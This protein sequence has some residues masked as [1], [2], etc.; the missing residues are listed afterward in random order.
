MPR[1]D[2]PQKNDQ[3]SSNAT[4]T[5]DEG[6]ENVGKIRPPRAMSS[7]H[8]PSS[9]GTM[10]WSETQRII[11][12]DDGRPTWCSFA[13]RRGRWGGAPSGRGCRVEAPSWPRMS[14]NIKNEETSSPESGRKRWGKGCG[15]GAMGGGVGR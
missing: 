6:V 4:F 2:D 14:R 8:L 15:G 10:A 13:R 11:G 3:G 7:S 9:S 5:C 12:S 1:I